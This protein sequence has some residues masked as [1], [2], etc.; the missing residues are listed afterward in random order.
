MFNARSMDTIYITAHQP[1]FAKYITRLK[2]NIACP[3]QLAYLSVL[4]E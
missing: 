3:T 4:L 2:T 1:Y